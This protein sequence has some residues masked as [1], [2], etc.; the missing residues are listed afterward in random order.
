MGFVSRVLGICVTPRHK[1]CCHVSLPR[2]AT[3]RRMAVKDD[4]L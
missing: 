1:D 2:R 4:W 3:D